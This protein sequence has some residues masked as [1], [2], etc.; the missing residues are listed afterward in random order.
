M[1]RRW[2]GAAAAAA[3]ILA[4]GA[5]GP[6]AVAAEPDGGASA[7]VGIFLKY[8]WRG[9]QLSEGAVVQPSIGLTRGPVA[10]SIWSNYDTDLKTLNETDVD[11]SYTREIG[12]VSLS[13][14]YVYYGLE[15]ADDTQE[16]YVAVCASTVLA[17]SLTVYGDFDEGDGFF[18]VLAVEHAFAL[19]ADMSL[20]IGATASYD[21][22]NAVMGSDAGG[23][24]LNCLY[25]GEVWISLSVPLGRGV[26]IDPWAAYAFPLSGAAGDALEA[27]SPG[28]EPD[29]FY[30]GATL[31][32]TF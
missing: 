7:S 19:P 5:L 21:G 8:V 16:V 20:K 17:P 2:I 22:G 3:I 10:V 27:L 4:G 28:G 13:L 25:S 23:G 12:P 24:A 14:G 9:Q 31:S 11:L 18:A 15:G 26:S 6:A 29:V 32:L 30:A 1:E